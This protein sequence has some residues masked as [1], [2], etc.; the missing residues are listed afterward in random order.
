M[1]DTDKQLYLDRAL[2]AAD[3][4]VNSQLEG[5]F[6]CDAN[7]ARFL[8]Y[9]Y[10][11]DKKWIPGINWS[12]GRAL[13]VLTDA[14]NITGDRRYLDAAE[15]GA[16]YIRALQPL[17]PYYQVTHGVIAE[18]YPHE[19]M[20]GILDGAQAASGMLML[21]RVTGNPDYLRRGKAFCDFLVRTWRKDV[22]FPRHVTYWPE[23]IFYP[24]DPIW[25]IGYATA[26]PLW[27]AYNITGEGQYVEI[28]VQAADFIL[29][30]QR[31]DGGMNALPEIDSIEEL[32]PNHHWGLGE[33]IDQYLLRNDDGIV[34]VVL[35]AYQVTGDKKYLDA[36]VR[37][38]DWTVEN[39]PHVRPFN[40][41][42]VQAG[43]VLDVGSISGKDYTAWVLEHLQERCL[44]LQVQDSGDPMADGGFRGEDEEGDGGIFGGTSLDYVTTRTTCYMAGTLFRLSGQGTGT[45]FSVH[46]LGEGMSRVSHDPQDNNAP[47][48]EGGKPA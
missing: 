22:G 9:Y 30:S 36:M 43:N 32:P 42:G 15:L 18:R 41:F 39:E 16:R 5:Q 35:A 26:I 44:D 47:I 25:M 17:D 38:A 4:F 29:T 1:N 10:M 11:P 14:Y 12:H 27:H 37:Y 6:S 7:A 23:Q 31:E 24:G 34:T 40:A 2:K 45:G 19:N 21:H 20:G 33:G 48:R 13:F 46:G 8:Y 3:W 28:L